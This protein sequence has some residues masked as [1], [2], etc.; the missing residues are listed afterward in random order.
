MSVGANVNTG[1][2]QWHRLFKDFNW[3]WKA[4]FILLKDDRRLDVTEHAAEQNEDGPKAKT[5]TKWRY[6]RNDT[7]Y[8]NN[9]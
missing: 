7:L 5:E 2:V 3:D 8:F 1:D 4:S 9:V 6:E